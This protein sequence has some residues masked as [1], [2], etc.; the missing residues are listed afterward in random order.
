MDIS[1]IFW[2]FPHKIRCF[3]VF[4]RLKSNF[5]GVDN[6][7]TAIFRSWSFP[8]G[9]GTKQREIRCF[10]GKKGAERGASHKEVSKSYCRDRRPR[11]SDSAKI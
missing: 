3:G 9:T 11:L 5:G 8:Q 4:N 7:R 2:N 10:D 6:Y 1:A